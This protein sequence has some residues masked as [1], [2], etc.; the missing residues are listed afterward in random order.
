MQ[1]INPPAFRRVPVLL[2]GFL[3]FA[4]LWLRLANLGYSDYQG[5]EIRSFWRP[6]P[7][8]SALA[9]LYAQG[10][11]PVQ[12]LVAALVKAV[13]PSYANQLLARLPYA[14]AG[15]LAI[16][17]FY[18]LARLHFGGKA[19]LYAALFLA[20]NGLFVGLMRI[21]QYQ[22]FVLLFSLLALY[23]FSLAGEDERWQRKGIYLGMLST[24]AAIFAHY[25][26]VFITPFAAYLLYRWYRRWDDLPPVTRLK[27]IAVPAV[28]GVLL[29]AAYFIPYLLRVPAGIHEYWLERI[30]WEEESRLLPSSLYIFQLYNPIIG[31]PVYAILCALALTRWKEAL[32]V[33]AWL[34]FPWVILELVIYDP[35]THLYTYIL[36]ATLL[37]GLGVLRLEAYV[38]R[39]TGELWGRRLNAVWTVAMFAALVGIS[40]LIFVDHT[41]EYPLQ[42]R[43]I[44][45]WIIGGRSDVYQQWNYGFPYYRRWEDIRAYLLAQQGTGFIASNEKSAIA[46]F[47]LPFANDLDQAGYYV[48]I[49]DPQHSRPRERR[50]KAR[51]WLERYPPVEVFEYDGRA[52]A[53]VYFM[54]SG[55]L[56]QIRSLGY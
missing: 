27:I 12:Y 14:L 52:V 48:F 44:L 28:L 25:D 23:C 2:S 35:G 17:V 21:V 39:L 20:S 49:H 15:I 5:D 55:T 29:L 8:Q 7:G 41:P 34:A 37:A 10:R 19:A 32:P 46:S 3:V 33:L 51:Y 30:T 1:G 26:G 50:P 36:P 45:L 18:K 42:Q 16:Y 31:L 38:E 40:H 54:P 6:A 13:D 9:F 56:Q 4:A 24:A 22:P 47:Y 43:R 11:G 53:E